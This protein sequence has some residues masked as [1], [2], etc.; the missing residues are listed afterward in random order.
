MSLRP[1]RRASIALALLVALP[2]IALSDTTYLVAD[3]DDQP[4]DVP[5]ATGG[6]A[7]GQP[8]TVD[9]F[10]T[11]T[12][13]DA[14]FPTPCLEIVDQHD[15]AAGYARFEFL[16]SAEPM[17]G[18]V[19]IRCS[20]WF[21]S[22]D[23]GSGYLI[24]LR[25]QGSSACSFCDLHFTPGGQIYAYD[26]DSNQGIIATYELGRAIP[27]IISVNLD[28]ATYDI[29]VDGLPVVVGN[30]HGVIGRGIGA[31]LVG[32][33]HDPDVGDGYFLDDL[34]VTDEVVPVTAAPQL[35]APT[36][37]LHPAT[38]NPFNPR[39]V[40]AFDLI[41]D[42][43]ARLRVCDLTGRVLATLVEGTLPAGTHCAIWQGVDARG[44]PVPSGVYVMR[45]E[46][47]GSV[48][49]RAVTLVR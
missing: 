16:D 45:L 29:W 44:R 42:A 20:L 43:G 4:L 49:Q 9:P 39:T 23:E 37:R 13:R 28:A 40:V 10:I 1:S 25:E 17:S 7:L 14:P 31:V 8:V 3:F 34:V 18:M 38:P 46:A 15:Y 27:I 12:V 35:A 32:C 26:Q 47:G 2:A 41:E 19:T 21:S 36:L 11:A 5:I 24:C 30:T 48:A 22:F 6:A 33:S